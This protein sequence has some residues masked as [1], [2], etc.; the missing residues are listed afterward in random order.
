MQPVGW[1]VLAI[2]GDARGRSHAL[3]FSTAVALRSPRDEGRARAFLCAQAKLAAEHGGRVLPG[4][5][6]Y[7]DA[8]TLAAT[9]GDE[10]ATLR[11]LKRRWDP[12]G[13]FGGPFYQQVLLPAM[14]R[15]TGAQPGSEVRPN[16][17]ESAGEE[18]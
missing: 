15:A 6:V 9:M 18:P 17:Q 11:R 1:D 13:L 3:R 7:A 16:I 14:L 12:A 10:L 2:R 4:K 5:G 8:E